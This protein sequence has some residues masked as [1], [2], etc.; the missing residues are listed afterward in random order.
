MGLGAR[1]EEGSIGPAQ[2]CVASVKWATAAADGHRTGATEARTASPVSAFGLACAAMVAFSRSS[3][4]S[5]VARLCSL[6]SCVVSMLV[7]ETGGTSGTS[8]GTSGGTGGTSPRVLRDRTA[9]VHVMSGNLMSM[10]E[11]FTAG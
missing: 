10:S 7:S 2:G 9:C 1:E 5:P 8:G 6:V 11:K 4:F 3:L